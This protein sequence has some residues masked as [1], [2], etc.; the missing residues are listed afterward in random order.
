MLGDCLVPYCRRCPCFGP[1]RDKCKQRV[2]IDACH[3]N[4]FFLKERAEREEPPIFVVRVY[5]QKLRRRHVG[6]KVLYHTTG[7]HFPL[8]NK[9]LGTFQINRQSAP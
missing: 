4:F 9:R 2:V 7:Q 8:G 3:L 6:R 1:A 5:F